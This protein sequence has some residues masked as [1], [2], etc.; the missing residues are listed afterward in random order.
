M[1]SDMSSYLTNIANTA[2]STLTPVSLVNFGVS[3]YSPSKGILTPVTSIRVGDV[4]DVQ[5]RRRDDMTEQYSSQVY[6]Y[7]P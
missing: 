3:V 5:R 2:K 6:P 7:T 1:A 4:F